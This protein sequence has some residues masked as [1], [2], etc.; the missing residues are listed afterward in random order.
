MAL[1]SVEAGIEAIRRGEM[2][3]LVDDE[4]RENEGDLVIAAERCT[5]EAIN[6][7]ARHGRGL[8]C[9]SLTDEQLRRLELPM[10]VENNSSPFET[11]FTVS[12]EARTGVTTG[13]SAQDRA[14]T[15]Q[16][17]IADQASPDD[18]VVPGHVFPL[19]A[20]PGGVLVRTGQ[21]EGSVDFAKLAGLKP[22]AV[23]CEILKEDGSMA[24]LPD[25]TRFAEEHQLLVCSIA[26]LIDY[27]LRRDRLVERL[28]ETP[29]PCA[30]GDDFRLRVYRSVV[31][32]A[33][34]LV[35]IHGKPEDAQGPVPV[36]VQHE[37]LVGD[38][39]RG[40]DTASGWQLH[41]ALDAIVKEGVGVV[42]YLGGQEL[43]R[44]D[45]VRRYVLKDKSAGPRRRSTS[46]V[47]PE[48]RDLG[49][50][51]QILVDCGVRQ[52][53]VLSSSSAQR[54]VGLDAYG[55]DLVGIE[56]IPRPSWARGD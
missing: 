34:H 28:V 51:C 43:S 7:M 20:R 3:I 17:A 50:G 10:M 30:H 26:D 35:L 12:I 53:K 18:I 24:R 25:L 54:L 47:K 15:V 32:G 31:D 44:Y 27:R 55:L 21:T 6:F 22:A 56:P 33:E 36:R 48:F 52:L 8:I 42:V 13:I 16:V 9:L 19:R 37:C 45:A 11:A 2:I 49:I 39:F 29:F 40:R 46:E 4:D 23:I 41:G 14:R 1:A 38:V 5:A